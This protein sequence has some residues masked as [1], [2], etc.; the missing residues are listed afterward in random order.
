MG[1][2]NKK[3]AKDL[4][5]QAYERLSGMLKAGI[6]QDKRKAKA[7][8]SARNMIFAVQTY[9]TYW[10]QNKYYIKWLR[11]SH[12]E[13]TTL[14]SAK[15]HVNEWLQLQSERT[16]AKGEHLSAWTLHTQRAALYKLFG[17]ESTDPKNFTPPQRN[18]TDIKRSR[19]KAARD[20]NFSEEKNAEFVAFCKGVG[21]RRNVAEKLEGRDLW[22][23]TRMEETVV[24]LRGIKSRSVQQ[25]KHLY[26]L[27]EALSV[28]P[29]QDL[30]VHHRKDKGGKYRFAPVIGP[31]KES[32]VKRFRSMK[33]QEK[34]WKYVSSNADIHSYRSDYATFMYRLYARA[35]EDI[36]YDKV[37]KGSGHRYQ[38]GLYI[39]R[40]NEKGKKLDR[41]ALEIVSKSLGHNRVCVVADHYLHDL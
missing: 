12:P 10:Q 32:I 37:N 1:R 13:C 26:A 20:M 15:R 21:C 33:E 35:P 17:M 34:V 6:G 29:D 19:K 5:Q 4:H 28:F 39:C 25:E 38:G 41:K 22:T 14:R 16:D 3:Y 24:L 11:K 18:K 31:A 36:P 30:Y 23:R 8:G 40:K 7:D 27:Q 2:K 9:R